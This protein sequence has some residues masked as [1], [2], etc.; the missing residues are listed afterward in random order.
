MQ[1][2]Y[3]LK[4]SN[5]NIYKE[6]QIP[7]DAEI[8]KIGMGIDCDVRFYK[9]SFFEDFE[10]VLQKKLN[11]WNITCSDNVFI[12]AGD[13]RKLI[14]KKLSHGDSFAIKYQ[15]SENEVFKIDFV[16]DFDDEFKNYEREVDIS[17]LNKF[18]IGNSIDCTFLLSSEYLKN[19]LIELTK[20]NNGYSMIISRS[21]YGIY[22][23]GILI[24]SKDTFIENNSFIS[25]ANFSFYLTDKKVYCTSDSK[26][27]IN[28]LNEN[29][30]KESKT[31]YDFPL[32][33]RNT[34]IQYDISEDEIEIQQPSP[35]PQKPKK[36]LLVSLI[37]SI[38][39]L[40]LMVI[41]RGIMGSGGTFVIYSVCSMGIGIVMSVVTYIMEGKDYKKEV[42]EREISYKQ[43][44]ADKE[45]YIQKERDNELR[46]QNLTY[47]SLNESIDEVENFGKRIFEKSVSDKDFLDVLLGTGTINAK[48][49]V[50]YTKQE[51]ADL[52]D[53]ISLLPEQIETKYRYIE[54]APIVSKFG[55][56]NGIGIIGSKEN[57]YSLLKNITLDLTIRHF[58]NDVRLFYIFDYSD[59]NNLNWIRWFPHVNEKSSRNFVCDEESKNACFESLYSIL[60]TRESLKKQKENITF[61]VRYVVFV[62]DNKELVKHPISK[63]FECG[64]ELGF[65]F[66]FFEEYEEFVPKGCTEI[67]RLRNS[68]DEGV[69]L[70]SING[71]VQ[72]TFSY[73]VI[74]EKIAKEVAVKLSEIQIDEVSLESQLTKNISLF[75]LLNIMSVDDLKLEER[76]ASSQVYNSLA[77]PLGVKS[78]NEIVYLDISDKANAHGPHGLVAGTTGSGKSEI[79]Q[80]Y[81]LS[82][83]TLFNPYDVGFVV[84]DFKGGGMAN[85]FK[86]LP[87][88]IGTITNIDGREIDRSLLSIK[89]EL[90]KRQNYFAQA[91][92]NHI[93]D[94]IK[95]Y[96]KGDVSTPLPHLIMIVDE[97]AELKAEYPDF[98]K[99]LISAAR[100]G[101]TLGVHLILAT[102][103]PAGVVDSQIWSNSKFKLC[104]KVQSKDDSNEVIKTPLA[105]EIVEPGRAYFQVGNNEIFELFQSAYSGAKVPNAN[106][107]SNI[108]SIFELN[109]WGK[110]TQVY[111]NKKNSNDSETKDQLHA[112]VEYVSSYCKS[113]GI[114]KLPGICLPALKD[115][116][117]ESELF[118]FINETQDVIVPIGIYDDP[119]EQKQDNF[120]I[121][122]TE[123]NSLIVGSSMSGKTTMLQ[124]VLLQ[125]MEK[126]SPKDVNVYI[127]DC[128]NMALKVFEKSNIVGGI[129]L[130]SEEEKVINLFKMLFAILEERKETLAKKDLGTYKAYKE[131]GYGDMPQIVLMIDNFAVFKEYY[132]NLTDDFLTLSRE[133]TSLG[134]S[135]IVTATQTNAMNYK[136]ISNYSTKI[137]Y[138]CNDTN[139]YMNMFDRCRI[140]PK[141]VPGRGLCVVDKKILEFQTALCVA[142]DKEYIRVDNIK[143]KIAGCNKKYSSEKANEIPVVPSII[144]FDDVKN[145]KQ[146][147]CN[148][149]EIPIGIN[150]S[151]VK[152]QVIDLL[153]LGLLIS[154]GREKSG[155]TNFLKLLLASIQ[156]NVFGSYTKAYVFDN[157]ERNLEKTSEYG[158]VNKYSVDLMELEQVLVEIENELVERKERITNDNEFSLEKEPLILLVI[159][160]TSFVDYIQNNKDL[161]SKL[162]KLIKQYK[163][164][165]FAVVV[166]D[167]T[168]EAIPFSA[169][170]FL[171]FVKDNR[172]FILFDDLSECKVFDVNIKQIKQNAKPL[173]VGDAF[174]CT[175]TEVQRIKTIFMGGI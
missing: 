17:N 25:I 72:R 128:G 8:M 51:F 9:E 101:R 35:K 24:D 100:I 98:M 136:A 103:K 156:N 4:I 162:C 115:T 42:E 93:N 77:A 144:S 148:N 59:Y 67:I 16:Y 63:Y 79:L 62:L 85:Q 94:Y 130:C 40:V 104:L 116:I 150:Y 34:R 119:E 3:L 1:Y 5:K 168:N 90:V 66:V 157:V 20:V 95:L 45:E 161:S 163:K 87:H 65:T 12:D 158:F 149:Y 21:T 30:V 123:S 153:K 118:N 73:P 143:E 26:L 78:G 52:K 142:G 139:E 33:R 15:K 146:L 169:S 68:S 110:R 114:T 83:S 165:R 37:P 174:I 14:T 140:E 160:N 151:N 141:E 96:K 41:L 50:K 54:N 36:N 172:N 84:I 99:E 28:N 44:I 71:D 43:Y 7:V 69:A 175:N 173:D 38:V 127:I 22:Y 133:G 155:Q 27:T 109:T 147:Y 154:I 29:I 91:G 112:I 92:V 47:P 113:K 75:D 125:L 2:G 129:A 10:L 81:V 46:I 13:V 171:K 60:S 89:A 70:F 122:L 117:N 61:N 11:E 106:V 131:A 152:Y 6:V 97:F 126:Y 57:R 86:E 64:K 134:V 48:N 102:Q 137:A 138:S 80:T 170:E 145:N 120:C 58:Y 105:A 111:T 23:N 76:W 108:F 31:P 49:P 55:Q 159:E 74:D 164:Y 135:I 82:L 53:K 124:T 18:T 39:M 88:L 132:E 107:D 19:D 166:S 56:S 167:F 32:F 121:N